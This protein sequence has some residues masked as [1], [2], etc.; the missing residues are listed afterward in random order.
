M[1]ILVTARKSKK[2]EG[3]VKFPI[4]PGYLD[5]VEV[6]GSIPPGPIMI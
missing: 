2:R 6:D 1:N 5:T 3:R 4:L